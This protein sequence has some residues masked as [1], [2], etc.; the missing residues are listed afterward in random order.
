MIN[1]GKVALNL[2]LATAYLG[3]GVCEYDREEQ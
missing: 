1:L 3:L 2:D